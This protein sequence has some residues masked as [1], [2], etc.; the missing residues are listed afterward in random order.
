M[1]FHCNSI[2]TIA[3]KNRRTKSGFLRGVGHTVTANRT[4]TEQC[5]PLETDT[6]ILNKKFESDVFVLFCLP[7]VLPGCLVVLICFVRHSCHTTFGL[8]PISFLSVSLSLICFI[9]FTHQFLSNCKVIGALKPPMVE[10]YNPPPETPQALYHLFLI[11]EITPHATTWGPHA[12]H[13][14]PH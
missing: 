13:F 1:L 2:V 12:Y 11:P 9:S 5:I 3:Q 6:M 4:I 10:I 7:V 8:P 14:E